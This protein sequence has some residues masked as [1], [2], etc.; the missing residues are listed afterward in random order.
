MFVAMDL[1]EMPT[2]L[3]YAHW[4]MTA[5]ASGTVPPAA[6]YGGALMTLAMNDTDTS[7][8]LFLARTAY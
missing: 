4:P 5:L 3:E 8:Q 2:S 1:I 7:F 6:L